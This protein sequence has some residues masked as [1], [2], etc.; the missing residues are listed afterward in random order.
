MKVL[1]SCV[2]CV[3]V[4][5]VLCSCAGQRPAKEKHD[6]LAYSPTAPNILRNYSSEEKIIANSKNLTSAKKKAIEIGAIPLSKKA[7]PQ[8]ENALASGSPVVVQTK[9]GLLLLIGH[10]PDKRA[11]II[12]DKEELRRIDE[13]KLHQI[14][15]DSGRKAASFNEPWEITLES[16]LYSAFI[17]GLEMSET[18][19]RK[20]RLLFERLIELAPD[21]PGPYL[22]LANTYRVND[23]DKAVE[24]LQEGVKR[25]PNEFAL[26][27]NLA[28]YQALS[29]KKWE[30]R[31]TA[32]KAQSMFRAKD[33][34][35]RLRGRLGL[36]GSN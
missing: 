9:D 8:I 7:Y 36:L 34:P 12:K 22:A 18:S 5:G 1:L 10:D 15:I 14:Y 2:I 28:A 3:L 11:F 32:W 16:D 30:S 33:V 17:A 20:A 13:E 6:S 27:Y 25:A 19:P 24:A 23:A 21:A 4:L 26:W 35:S 29:G 31:K